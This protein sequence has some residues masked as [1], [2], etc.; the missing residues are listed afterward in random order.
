M[1]RAQGW[2]V[3]EPA[4]R[5]AGAVSRLFA[6]LGLCGVVLGTGVSLAEE[7]HSGGQAEPLPEWSYS[8]ESAAVHWG[9]LSPKFSACSEGRQQ[10]PIDILDPVDA[11]L[12]ALELRYGL[13]LEQLA[14]TGHAL[15]A[16]VF[17]GS[18]L[19]ANGHRFELLEFHFHSP[20]ENR[21]GGKQFPLEAHFV[22]RGLRG[23]IAMLG[24][25]FEVGA[26]NRSLADILAAV[27]HG[28]GTAEAGHL[29]LRAQ[30]L[31]PDE[32]AYFLYSGSLTTPPCTEGVRWFVMQT[33]LAGSTPQIAEFLA[34]V[35]PN[36]RSAQPLHSRLVLR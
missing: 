30:D 19:V 36:A 13:Q 33:P 8:G 12:P 35:G 32:R 3:R 22:H 27:P 15:Q 31:L 2:P 10:A 6:A 17:P 23:E 11:E 9:S 1:S 18:W 34:A 4:A 20:S 14:H 7:R 25:L 21:I 16:F 26:R 5:G 28:P 29:K 24:V